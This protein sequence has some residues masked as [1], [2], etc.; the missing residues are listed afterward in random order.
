[1]SMESPLLLNAIIAWSSSHLA[2]RIKSYEP[3]AI[4]NRCLA[5]QSLSASLSSTTRNP[6]MELASCLIHCAIESITGDTKEWFNHLV[7]AYEV[8]RSVTSSEDTSQLDLSRF[9]T[10]FEGRWLLRSFAYHDILMTVVEDRKPLIIAGEYWN[11]ASDA[12]VADSYFGLASRLMYL[13]SRISILNGD[14]MDCADGSASAESFS[15]EAQ[16]IQQELV[17]W[18]CG[19]SD[20][21]MLVHLA[22]TYRSAALIH[23]FR[24]IRQHRPQLTA[25]LAPRIATQAKEIVTRIEKMPANCLA[26]SSLLLPLFMAG[27][28]VEDPEQIAVIRHRMQDIVEVRQFHNVQAVLT[29]LEEVWHLRA[30]GVLGPGRRK[31]DWKDVLARRKWMLSIT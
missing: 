24:T 29:V 18:T 17:S 10:T 11:F 30:T 31:V 15:H 5:L 28:E 14:M 1:M 6:E 7:G 8:I 25:T 13:I 9:S 12:L 19:Q 23:L 3:I 27:G 2:L 20:N 22:E 16:T 26:E 4:A 21:A